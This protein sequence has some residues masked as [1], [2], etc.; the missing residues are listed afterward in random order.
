MAVAS[1]FCTAIA[2]LTYFS[3]ACHFF[4]FLLSHYLCR[5][6]RHCSMPLVPASPTFGHIQG[7]FCIVAPPPEVHRKRHQIVGGLPFEG[8]TAL[9]LSHFVVFSSDCSD[10]TYAEQHLLT[11]NLS[12]VAESDWISVP[13]P[14]TPQGRPPLCP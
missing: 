7:S 5:P 9:L 2:S 10:S 3:P 6:Q 14:H 1:M 12:S 8:N 4:S 11:D 13:P